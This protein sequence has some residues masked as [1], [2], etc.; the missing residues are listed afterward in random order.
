M[1]TRA[2]FVGSLLYSISARFLLY[3]MSVLEEGI[4]VHAIC[5]PL[6][7]SL[8]SRCVVS[9]PIQ[10]NP[11]ASLAPRLRWHCT[12]ALLFANPRVYPKRQNVCAV[13]PSLGS[14]T[15]CVCVRVRV[16]SRLLLLSSIVAV[17]VC[18]FL[19]CLF[20][21]WPDVMKLGVWYVRLCLCERLCERQH[22]NGIGIGIGIGV[23]IGI[24]HSR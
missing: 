18:F 9:N 6:F 1:A 24:G 10:S 5:T 13:M 20:P 21:V 3:F 17:V 19:A 7:A 11:N 14:V 12:Q 4:S 2:G 8:Q 23:G 16:C 22:S 15:L